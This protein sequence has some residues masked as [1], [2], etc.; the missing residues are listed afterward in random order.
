MPEHP[1]V[2]EF[3]GAITVTDRIGTI[4]EVNDAAA[5]AFHNEGGQKL[6]GTN[7]LDCH[8]EPSRTRLQG[9]M[10]GRTTNV[11]TIQKQGSKK[12]IY[13]SPWYRDGEYAG[14]VELC[15]DIPW[16]MPHFVRD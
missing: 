14:F 5:E 16:E 12:L 8:P 7:V 4:L 13:Q 11:Y 9:I 15:L 10:A 3:P 2:R 6:V 1:W